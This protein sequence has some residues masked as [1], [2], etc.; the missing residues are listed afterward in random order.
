MPLPTPNVWNE[1]ELGKMT[2]EAIR[3][4][5]Q[6][7][8]AYR[9]SRYRYPAGTS[10]PGAQKSTRCYVLSGSCRHTFDEPIEMSRGTWIDL[11]AGDFTLEV[12][13][14]EELDIV[15]V[16]TLPVAFRSS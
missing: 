4:L 2:E 11:P 15:L 13:G 14:D 7:A 5:H 3:A 16:W 1:S 12:L 8:E 9:I 6:P 10:F